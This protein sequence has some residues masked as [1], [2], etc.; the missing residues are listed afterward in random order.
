MKT[1]RYIDN[2][3]TLVLEPGACVGCGMCTAVCP[4]AVLV[5]ENRKARVVDRD[6]CMEC[7]ACANNCPTEAI[8]VTPGVGCAS[9]IIQ[10]WIKGKENASCCCG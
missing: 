2:V 5:L 4:H 3:A 7:G 6:G 8:R 10:S 1:F 9:Y